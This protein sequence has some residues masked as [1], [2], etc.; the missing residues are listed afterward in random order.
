MHSLGHGD[1]LSH[2]LL[3]H[4]LA[5]ALSAA[6]FVLSLAVTCLALVLLNDLVSLFSHEALAV[7]LTTENVF[8][9]TGFESISITR[10][11][12]LVSLEL[13]RAGL[14]PD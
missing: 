1:H 13:D 12:I 5:L 10:G 7:T 6:L 8:I 9:R 14:A 2:C 3:E 4:A 11:A